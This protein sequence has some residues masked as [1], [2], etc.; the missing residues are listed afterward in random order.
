MPKQVGESGCPQIF[1]ILTVNCNL[2]DRKSV[3]GTEVTGLV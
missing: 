2:P 1:H 3:S